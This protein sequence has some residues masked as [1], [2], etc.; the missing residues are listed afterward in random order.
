MNGVETGVAVC[1]FAGNVTEVVTGYVTGL[2]PGVVVKSGCK[3]GLSEHPDKI[4]NAITR[5]AMRENTILLFNPPASR[6]ILMNSMEWPGNIYLPYLPK[7]DP[8]S[9]EKFSLTV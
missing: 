4:T 5:P 7:S 1:G 2:P 9:S 3:T 8:Y 6:T